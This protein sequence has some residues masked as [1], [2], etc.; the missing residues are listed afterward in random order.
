[1]TLFEE[2][3]TDENKL[4]RDWI[5]APGIAVRNGVLAFTPERDEGFCLAV[6]R[7][8][9]FRDFSMEADVRIVSGAVGFVL[10]VA[11]PG[12]YYMVQFDIANDPSV[13]WFHTFTPEAECGYRL[14]LVP[15]ALVPQVGVWHRM[16]VVAN[17]SA[18]EVFL[19]EPG[20]PLTLDAIRSSWSGSALRV[21]LIE[22]GTRAG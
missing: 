15:S 11:A 20:G 18:F 6:T 19:G 5:T 17:D 7:Q 3:F 16:R 2:P 21:P 12:Q 4:L 8:N 9:D 10:R 22:S 1:M 13:V 14:D